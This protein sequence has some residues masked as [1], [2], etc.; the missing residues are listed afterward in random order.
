MGVTV[1]GGGGKGRK[2]VDAELNLIPFI[3]LLSTCILFLL[4]TA[5]WVQ[6]SRMSA[7]TQP[8][9]EATV[10][11][12]EVSSINEMREGRE[13][14]ILVLVD[15]VELIEKQRSIGKWPVV[16]FQMRLPELKTRLKVVDPKISVR[17]A[18]EVVYEN[19]VSVLDVLISNQLTNI[20]IGG[21]N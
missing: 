8:T 9:G 12:S 17:A 16:E 11:H 4:M 5:V 7:F 21:L 10:R 18:D 2:S 3:D 6:I 20:T 13:W 15:G 19:V 1:Q 14:D